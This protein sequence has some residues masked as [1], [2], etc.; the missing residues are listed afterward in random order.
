M[1]RIPYWFLIAGTVVAALLV[2]DRIFLN[3]AIHRERQSLAMSQQAAASAPGYENAWKQLAAGIYRASAQ[4]PAL[5]AM[6]KRHEITIQ[7][8]PAAISAHASSATPA[9]S[10]SQAISNQPSPVNAP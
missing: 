8:R 9:P 6:L 3:Q 4:D 7:V 10:E 5:A 1:W 2:V